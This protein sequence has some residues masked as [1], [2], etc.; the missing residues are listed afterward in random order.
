MCK[1]DNSKVN[2]IQVGEQTP[3]PEG[4]TTTTDT[5]GSTSGCPKCGK[6][7][8]YVGDVFEGMDLSQ[9]ICDGHCDEYVLFPTHVQLYPY[10]ENRGWIC[11]RC[12]RV[13]SPST[14]ECWECNKK[15][16]F[17]CNPYFHPIVEPYIY[18]TTTVSDSDNVTT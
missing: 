14:T 4:I 3:L 8:Y 5:S 7:P 10:Q 17:P 6:Q 11:P 1:S 16:V 12:G 13:Y 2:F 9:L 15:N 18:P